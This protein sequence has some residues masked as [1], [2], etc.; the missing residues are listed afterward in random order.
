MMLLYVLRGL[1]SKSLKRDTR[2]I[3]KCRVIVLPVMVNRRIDQSL[4]DNS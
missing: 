1:L 2:S 4:I 3:G